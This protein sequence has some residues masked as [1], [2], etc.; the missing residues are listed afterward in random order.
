MTSFDDFDD[1]SYQNDPTITEENITEKNI[2]E[3]KGTG[4]TTDGPPTLEQIRDYVAREHIQVDSQ[5]FF[6]YYSMRRWRD[7]SGHIIPDWKAKIRS[8]IDSL[9]LQVRNLD[10]LLYELE[11]QGY[12]VKKGKYMKSQSV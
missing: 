7:K 3:R 6:D 1:L 10:E 12:E 11:M 5:H 8:D 9:I 4:V 2:T